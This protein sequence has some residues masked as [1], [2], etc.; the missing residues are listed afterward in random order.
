MDD[1]ATFFNALHNIM[2]VVCVYLNGSGERSFFQLDAPSN[3]DASWSKMRMQEALKIATEVH[4]VRLCL[5]IAAALRYHCRISEVALSGG[6]LDSDKVQHV[7]FDFL[8]VRGLLYPQEEKL[9]N[10]ASGL[11]C[12]EIEEGISRCCPEVNFKFRVILGYRKTERSKDAVRGVKT[13]RPFFQDDRE[14][15]RKGDDTSCGTPLPLL[16]IQMLRDCI[17]TPA[18]GPAKNWGYPER[19]LNILEM[20]LGRVSM[21]FESLD[22]LITLPL[23]LSYLQHCKLLFIL[24]V[25]LYPLTTRP[26]EGFWANVIS[27]CIIFTALLGIEVLAD[28]LENPLGDDVV[29]MNIYEMIH[30]MEARASQIFAFAET[31]RHDLQVAQLKPL[32]AMGLVQCAESFLD[33]APED[34]RSARM[35]V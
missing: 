15:H 24:F 5:A 6:H 7:L 19:L 1:T 9:L 35:F 27:P 33:K 3:D 10:D 4:A 32:E 13:L 26:D 14:K 28:Q 23:P 31:H 12:E 18:L 16:L 17:Y 25:I 21:S 30:D 20:E 11:W 34:R 29:D 8:R 2:G 22:R